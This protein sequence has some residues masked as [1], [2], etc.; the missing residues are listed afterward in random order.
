M[1]IKRK[2]T[3]VGYPNPDIDVNDENEFKKIIS[4]LEVN[5]IKLNNQH[6][7]SQ[8][9]NLKSSDW[10]KNFDDYKGKL[11]CPVTIKTRAAELD[12]FLG[13]AL[14][15]E[16]EN[17]KNVWNKHAIEKLKTSNVPNVIADNPLDN[18]N[19]TSQEFSKGINELAQILKIT[20]HPDPLITLEAC[21]KIIQ[22]RL[23]S[24]ALENP[25]E[26]IVKG[27]PFP[28]QSADLGFDLGETILNQAAKLLRLLY[29]QDL[30]NLQTK[31]NEVIVAV[32]SVTANPK[33]DTKLGKVG[34]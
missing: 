34:F 32:Q 29:I 33:T 19:F 17:Q 6:I 18:L 7:A 16:Y 20:P 23:H 30:R 13:H 22:K 2:L 3:A 9:N 21:S 4:W 28:Y 12:W 5:K 15:I 31:A 10:D 27:N 8:L 26:Y 24:Q 14:Q 25:N 1:V 11:G